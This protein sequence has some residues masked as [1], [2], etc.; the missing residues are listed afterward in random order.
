MAVNRK[1]LAL[2]P[3]A[4]GALGEIGSASSPDAREAWTK[5]TDGKVTVFDDGARAGVAID[6]GRVLGPVR[7]GPLGGI[8][9]EVPPVYVGEEALT[10][11]ANGLPGDHGAGVGAAGAAGE[12]EGAPQE[13]EGEEGA[14]VE[15]VAVDGLKLDH[16]P[17]NAFDVE[18]GR[19]NLARLHAERIRKEEKQRALELASPSPP[20]FSSSSLGPSDSI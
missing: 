14:R 7:D 18:A 19:Q 9:R 12:G 20:A 5:A 4:F 13:T 8:E 16:P 2:G 1:W 3:R 15:H 11:A 17:P 6:A 10:G